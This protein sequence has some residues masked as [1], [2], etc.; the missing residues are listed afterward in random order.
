VDF[1]DHE[2]FA[3]SEEDGM[4]MPVKLSKI[5]RKAGEVHNR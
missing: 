1:L 4:E 2:Q 3:P 5:N